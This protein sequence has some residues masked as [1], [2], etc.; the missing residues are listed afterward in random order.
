MIFYT[1][2]IPLHKWIK[3]KAMT[4]TVIIN[5]KSKAAKLMLE[6]LKT[7]PYVKIVEENEPNAYLLQSLDEAKSG[8]VIRANNVKDLICKMNE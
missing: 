4:T 2:S 8:K 5:N 1:K 7:Q 3:Q 6:Y